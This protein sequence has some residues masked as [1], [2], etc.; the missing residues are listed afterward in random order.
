MLSRIRRCT[1]IC[2]IFVPPSE[3][4]SMS[5]LSNLY[6]SR[7]AV[8]SMDKA[9][10]IHQLH[11]MRNVNDLQNVATFGRNCLGSPIQIRCSTNFYDDVMSK[12]RG[13]YTLHTCGNKRGQ[14]VRFENLTSFLN[15]KYL[16]P[17]T[18]LRFPVNVELGILNSHSGRT[19]SRETSLAAPTIPIIRRN[20]FHCKYTHRL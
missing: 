7:P 4:R 1:L 8:L 20:I 5:D 11:T 12:V 18:L 9:F 16:R 14:D 2:D 10:G 3:S 15:H 17:D 13:E 19:V 6:S